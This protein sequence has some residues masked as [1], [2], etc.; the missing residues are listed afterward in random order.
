MERVSR[1]RAEAEQQSRRPVLCLLRVASMAL[2]A[3]VIVALGFVRF[4]A[5]AA[6]AVGTCSTTTTNTADCTVEANVAFAFNPQNITVASGVTVTWDNTAFFSHTTTSDPKAVQSWNDSL[7]G[8]GSA[9]VTF[10][11]LGDDPYYCTI[12]G[13]SSTSPGGRG[14]MIGDVNVVGT[15]AA[16]VARFAITRSGLIVHAKWV[17]AVNS[18]VMGFYLGADHRAF[19]N[20]LIPVHTGR[21]YETSFRYSGSGPIILHML[22]QDGSNSTTSVHART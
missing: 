1:R 22:L 21:A 7:T 3:V 14:G 16:R 10:T 8:G 13:S 19:E 6:D 4:G 17:L 2:V 12:H 11:T 20:R 9:G 18:G 5:S 15:T